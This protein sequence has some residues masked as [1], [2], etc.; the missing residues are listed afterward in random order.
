MGRTKGLEVQQ[1]KR[2]VQGRSME[3]KQEGVGPLK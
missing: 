2:W 1:S 3:S